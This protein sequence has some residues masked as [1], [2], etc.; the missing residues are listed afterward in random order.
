VLELLRSAVDLV[1]FAPLVQAYME[2]A[3]TIVANV[4][5]Y[6]ANLCQQVAGA[7]SWEGVFGLVKL[8]VYHLGILVEFGF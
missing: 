5:T 7:V 8:A 1:E 6:D 2:F 3:S 4:P